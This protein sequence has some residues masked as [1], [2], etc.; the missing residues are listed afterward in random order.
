MIP[1]D[2]EAIW[3]RWNAGTIT[4][5]ERIAMARALLEPVIDDIRGGAEHLDIQGFKAELSELGADI[6]N[7]LDT[8]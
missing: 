6:D 2:F 7:A 1:A 3:D 8:A 4:H 5:E